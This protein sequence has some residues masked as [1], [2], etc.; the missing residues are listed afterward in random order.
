MKEKFEI[1]G[2]E[3]LLNQYGVLSC[4]E[5]VYKVLPKEVLL[6]DLF[7]KKRLFQIRELKLDKNGSVAINHLF[8][9]M[10]IMWNAA[11]EFIQYNPDLKTRPP[12]LLTNNDYPLE[13]PYFG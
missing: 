8:C 7:Y 13:D 12:S 9:P 5:L 10:E 1:K 4:A 2:I 3:F 11:L 6:R